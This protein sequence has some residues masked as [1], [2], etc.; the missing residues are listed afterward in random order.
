MPAAELPVTKSNWSS[1]AVCSRRLASLPVSTCRKG[2]MAWISHGLE[3]V[4]PQPDLKGKE[5][6]GAAVEPPSQ[7]NQL[8][9]QQATST[10]WPNK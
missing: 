9:L 10:W 8:I 2:V 6:V 5:P 3:K 1:E 4:V 7:V